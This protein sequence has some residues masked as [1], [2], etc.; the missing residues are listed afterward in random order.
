MPDGLL[1]GDNESFVGW[2]F[3]CC[4][5]LVDPAFPLA[6]A[7]PL[8]FADDASGGG[9]FSESLPGTRTAVE[10][11]SDSFRGRCS[12]ILGVPDG[13]RPSTGVPR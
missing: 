8:L 5:R 11:A 6:R 12:G 2:L 9:R 1:L 13:L 10:K 4:C 3:C 7:L